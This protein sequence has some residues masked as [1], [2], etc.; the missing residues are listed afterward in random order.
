MPLFA[1]PGPPL[2]SL[3]ASVGTNPE[4]ASEMGGSHGGCSE[5]TPSRIEPQAGKVPKN[6]GEPSLPEPMGILDEDGGGL[7]LSDDSGELPPESRLWAFDA[8]A[9]SGGRDVLAWEAARDDINVPSPGPPVECAHVVPDWEAGKDSLALSG[10]EYA[11]AEGSK[12]NS[13]DGAPAK[14]EPSQNASTRPCEEG[15]FSQA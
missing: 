3:A 15:E 8:R 2:W 1:V 6:N 9:S 10:E 11:S 7:H 4:P 14:Q 12:L 13:A 5:H